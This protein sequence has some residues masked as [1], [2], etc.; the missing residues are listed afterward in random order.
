[1]SLYANAIAK[2]ITASDERALRS[3]LKRSAASVPT[4]IVEGRAQSTDAEF[5]RFLGY[6][7][8]SCS[9]T[10]YHAL[11]ARDKG[12]ISPSKC[13]ALTK[14]VVEVR[15]MLHGLIDKLN[16]DNKKS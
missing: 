7:V 10:E 2:T 16:G 1:M 14:Q 9:E 5:A 11:S 3:Q 15:M 4:N 13:E 6:A 8:A 12:L